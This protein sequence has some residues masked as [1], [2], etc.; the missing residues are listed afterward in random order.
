MRLPL[1]QRLGRSTFD[2]RTLRFK[3]QA[4]RIEAL[5]L[6]FAFCLSCPSEFLLLSQLSFSRRPGLLFFGGQLSSRF[7][8]CPFLLDFRQREL[9]LFALEPQLFSFPC[10]KL[11]FRRLA[12]ERLRFI[13]GHHGLL[14]ELDTRSREV[15]KV[16]PPEVLVLGFGLRVL[17]SRL[18]GARR[19]S[20]REGRQRRAVEGKG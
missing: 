3:A 17:G 18:D 9:Y 5:P 13:G 12:R 16:V 19:R 7:Q 2:L 8:D 20:S 10:R 6:R 1:G 11:N 14:F 15:C 4:L